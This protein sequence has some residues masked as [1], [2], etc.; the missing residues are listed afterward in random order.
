MTLIFGSSFCFP[1][2]W[3][4]LNIPSFCIPYTIKLIQRYHLS[5][6]YLHQTLNLWYDQI[7]YEEFCSLSQKLSKLIFALHFGS[8]STI[9]TIIYR[10]GTLRRILQTDRGQKARLS[11]DLILIMN[12]KL[13]F[14]TPCTSKQTM[15]FHADGAYHNTLLVYCTILVVTVYV[16]SVG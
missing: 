12:E 8:G 13:L 9:H 3:F 10:L 1:Q 16:G 11:W 15:I 5:T 7:R 14:V 4:Q 2:S 6:P